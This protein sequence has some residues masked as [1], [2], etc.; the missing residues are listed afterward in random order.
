MNVAGTDV[1][2][3]LWPFDSHCTYWLA[4]LTAMTTPSVSDEA[5]GARTAITAWY[6]DASEPRQEARISETAPASIGAVVVLV[7]VKAAGG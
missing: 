3:P 6:C 1:L 2:L 7:T 4:E 5:T